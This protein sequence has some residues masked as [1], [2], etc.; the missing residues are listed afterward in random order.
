MAQTQDQA[1]MTLVLQGKNDAAAVLNQFNSQIRESLSVV[2]QFRGSLMLIGAT[3]GVAVYSISKMVTAY[4]KQRIQ[5]NQLRFALSRVGIEYDDVR[6]SL[7]SFLTS[8]GYLTGVSGERVQ[9]MFIQYLRIVNDADTATQLM[10]GTYDLMA[11]TGINEAEAIKLVTEA[12]KGNHDGLVALGFVWDDSKTDMENLAA[13]FELVKGKAAENRTEGTALS[14]NWKELAET[15]SKSLGPALAEVV[16]GLSTLVGWMGTALN[17][18][19]WDISDEDI[20][21]AIISPFKSAW[22]WLKDEFSWSGML[23]NFASQFADPFE[24]LN[25]DI[26][27][28]FLTIWNWGKSQVSDMWGML[29]TAFESQFA[30]PFEFLNWSMAGTFITVWYWIQNETAKIWNEMK[31]AFWRVWTFDMVGAVKGGVNLMIMALNALGNAIESVLSIEVPSWIPGIGGMGWHVN[32]PDIPRLSYQYG[33]VVPGPIGEPMPM[34]GHGG[35]RF[36]GAG[37]GGLGPI[38]IN[39]DG[40]EIARYTIDILSREAK[41]QRAW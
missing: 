33:G 19:G 26:V 14:A 15:A 29:I 13:V 31:E 32:I 8:M 1:V 6:N 12:L 25:W 17:W 10:A 7:E 5:T 41:L 20:K 40:R 2:R 27:G 34:I 35:E 37:G 9:S 11:A 16:G 38:I 23:D 39:L 3:V 28:K 24:F 30:D 4:E 36:L 22:E 21:N 18:K